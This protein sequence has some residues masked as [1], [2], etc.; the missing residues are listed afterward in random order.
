[1]HTVEMQ[2]LRWDSEKYYVNTKLIHDFRKRY[3]TAQDVLAG[4]KKAC[5]V[6]TLMY[7]SEKTGTQNKTT[8]LSSGAF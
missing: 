6:I 7:K 1:M 8:S 5:F 4:T 3:F 2:Y